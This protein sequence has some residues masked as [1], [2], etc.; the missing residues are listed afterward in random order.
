MTEE[1]KPRG[2]SYSSFTEYSACSR[3]WFIRKV[4]K[5]PIDTDADASTEAFDVGKAFHKCLEDTKHDLKGFTFQQCADACRSFNVEDPDTIAMVYAMLSKYK[6][7]HESTNLKVVGCEV[8][9]DVPGFYGITDVVMQNDAGLWIVDLK[10]ASTFQQST[11]KTITSH[12]QLLLYARHFDEI[13]YAVGLKDIPFAGVRLRTTTKSKLQRK[14]DEVTA[15][16]I[17]RM[18]KSIKSSDIV[19]PAKYLGNMDA[20]FQLHQRANEITAK[21]KPEDIEKFP[22]NFGHCFSYFRPCEHY[23]KC[24]NYNYTEAPDVEMVEV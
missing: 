13:A 23:S 17:A 2:L 7:L 19:V 15:D 6:K 9:V 10:T 3:K 4:L 22:P 11:L 20:V 8:V 21:A 16:Y 5:L 12:P 18:A 14:S 24:H 1:Q